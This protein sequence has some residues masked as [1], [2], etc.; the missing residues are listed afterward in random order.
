MEQKKYT[1]T[2]SELKLFIDFIWEN[3]NETLG[4]MPEKHIELYLDQFIE[5]KDTW[6]PEEE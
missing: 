1:L 5:V 3:S 4:Q 6:K 2:A